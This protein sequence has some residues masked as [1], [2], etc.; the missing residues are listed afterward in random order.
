LP[1]V[2]GVVAAVAW[3]DALPLPLW[4]T[5]LAL[6]GVGWAGQLVGHW[7]EGSRPAFFRDL[8]FLMI[9]PLW[10]I[11]GIYRRFNIPY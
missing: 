9:G 1:F 5:S 2:L 6:F 8:Q 4:T 11:A 3:L 7:L 10:L